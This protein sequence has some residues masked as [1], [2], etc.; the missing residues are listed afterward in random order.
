M[1]TVEEVKITGRKYRIWD[2]VNSVWKRISYWTK[3]CDV[4][5]NNG[6]NAEEMVTSM[7]A[8][9]NS[10]INRLSLEISAL[11]QAFSQALTDLKNTA[12]AKAVGAN[13]TTFASVISKLATIVNR[14]AWSANMSSS[15][16]VTIPAGYH[17]GA[18]TVKT[19][20]TANVT[21]NGTHNIAQ[22]TNVNV[23][24]D[25]SPVNKIVANWNTFNSYFVFS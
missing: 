2:A 19:N 18:G 23:N 22:Y 4:V 16:S 13:G 10:E 7:N 3:A 11:R 6:Q 12:I 15:A 25:V 9:L 17:N 5:F 8:H 24:V 1:A 20:G 21:T 14:G